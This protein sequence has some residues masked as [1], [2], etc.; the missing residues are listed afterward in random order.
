[1]IH[2]S[3]KGS[4]RVKPEVVGSRPAMRDIPIGKPVWCSGSIRLNSIM[5]MVVTAIK[6]SFE[7]PSKGSGS[8]PG[9]GI[10]VL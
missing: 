7:Y 4:L 9:A 3:C 6:I 8:I 10:K 1:M 2:I 5:K